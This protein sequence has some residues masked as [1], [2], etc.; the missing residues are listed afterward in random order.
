VSASRSNPKLRRLS[1]EADIP[2]SEGGQGGIREA[3]VIWTKAGASAS[4]RNVLLGALALLFPAAH[5]A[6]SDAG[7]DF[8]TKFIHSASERYLSIGLKEPP[9]QVGG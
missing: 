4:I 3:E 6:A 7:L 8:G 1:N 5:R 2:H 9:V